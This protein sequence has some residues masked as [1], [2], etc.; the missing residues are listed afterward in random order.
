MTSSVDPT[1]S[2]K[3]QASRGTCARFPSHPKRLS[4]C[5]LQRLDSFFLAI[6]NIP[7]PSRLRPLEV[8]IG[9]DQDNYEE[10]LI[11]MVAQLDLSDIDRLQALHE[12]RLRQGRG[13]SD[14]ELAF[15]M[16]MQNAR[17]N[18]Q[19]DADR[20]LALRLAL[21]G[22]GEPDPAPR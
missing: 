17:E 5:N 6:M 1:S 9:R 21:E 16:L 11:R 7:G 22:G 20:A 12:S 8:P 13:L 2:F 3:F 4:R 15:S 19:L 18:A 10:D 14:R